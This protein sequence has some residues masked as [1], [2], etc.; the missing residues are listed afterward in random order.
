[1]PP[2]EYSPN[3]P[4]PEATQEQTAESR[5]VITEPQNGARYVID[6]ERAAQLQQ[7]GVIVQAP[8]STREVLL[9][10]DGA[11]IGH[12]SRPFEFQWTL[13]AGEHRLVAV[14]ADGHR[15]DAV[16]L[17]VRSAGE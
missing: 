15:S 17:Q 10:V 5:L 16:L 8:V 6:P 12:A 11:V 13:R 1:L 7:L 2:D 14:D 4:A 9:E 3:C